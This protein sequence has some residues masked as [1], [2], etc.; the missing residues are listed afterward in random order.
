MPDSCFVCVFLFLKSNS[1]LH[2]PRGPASFTKHRSVN[3][4]CKEKKKGRKW[5]VWLEREQNEWCTVWS[6]ACL[7]EMSFIEF[8]EAFSQVGMQTE[9]HLAQWGLLHYLHRLAEGHKVNRSYDQPKGKAEPG[10]C[11]EEVFPSQGGRAVKR[12]IRHEARLPNIQTPNEE[13]ILQL[14]QAKACFDF[15]G[16]ATWPQ[17]GEG[18]AWQVYRCTF[19]LYISPDKSMR[20]VAQALLTFLC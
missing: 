9:P 1:S 7:S 18:W 19:L 5:W 6:S 14:L 4:H 20:H 8:N 2:C 3:K 12:K 17:K 16:R 10:I 11:W 13:K 15:K